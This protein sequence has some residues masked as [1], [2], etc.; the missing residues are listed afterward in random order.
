MSDLDKLELQ[1][2]AEG[3]VQITG[4]SVEPIEL[5]ALIVSAIQSMKSKKIPYTDAQLLHHV[6]KEVKTRNDEFYTPLLEE[7][8]SRM[9]FDYFL[10]TSKLIFKGV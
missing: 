5:K 8:D 2:R 6:R 9:T 7:S 1:I 4:Q 3:D 10:K